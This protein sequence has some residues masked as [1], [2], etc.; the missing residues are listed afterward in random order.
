MR[1]ATMLALVLVLSSGCMGP[2]PDLGVRGHQTTTDQCLDK[3]LYRLGAIDKE[4][5][6]PMTID[7]L[8]EF[9]R[10]EYAPCG[11]CSSE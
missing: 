10:E 8:I 6:S 5:P 7:L 11:S 4:Q 9:C 2:N 3:K 1:V